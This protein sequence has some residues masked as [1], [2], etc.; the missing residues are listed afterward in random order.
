VAKADN[1][2]NVTAR[3]IGAVNFKD[4][5]RLYFIFDR[6]T[7]IALRP[8]FGTRLGARQWDGEKTIE[9][10]QPMSAVATEEP[11]EVL[12]DLARDGD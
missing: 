5:K 10:T 12:T 3:I 4:G 9:H 6:N 2:E 11:V 7:D 1:Q 8:L